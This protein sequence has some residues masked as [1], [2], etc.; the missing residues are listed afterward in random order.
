MNRLLKF[1]LALLVLCLLA[2]SGFAQGL[3]NSKRITS[4]QVSSLWN[5]GYVM[6]N[7]HR[8]HYWRTGGDKPVMIL[9][10]GSSDNGLCWTCLVKHLEQDYDIIM[11]DAI[12]HGLSDAPS[13][14]DAPDAQVES[15]AGL[16]KEFNL[17]KPILM[18]HSMGS[19]S[20]AWFAAKYPDIPRAVILE[21]PYLQ[22]RTQ[23]DIKTMESSNTQRFQ[24][25]LKL[26]NKSFEELYALCLDKNEAWGTCEC[27]YWAYSKMQH[28]PSTAYVSRGN[29]PSIQE[30][31]G[32][33]TAPVLILKAD[34]TGDLRANNI[35]VTKLLANGQIEHI[36]GAKHN[37]RRD[38]KELLLEK[39]KG[40]LARIS[41]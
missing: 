34:D 18:G 21:D 28:H 3:Q 14:I 32:K 36:T 1:K 9:A 41:K 33:I 22:V 27:E 17:N 20:V 8:I 13:N 26:N 19:A 35:E 16:I 12:G 24:S 25:I 10:H 7:N 11:F 15:I 30:L 23:E 2:H 29:R 5:E 37:V 40:F 31:F 39:L 4:L 38:Q 6:A